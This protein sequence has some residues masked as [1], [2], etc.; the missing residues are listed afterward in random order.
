[1]K[2]ITCFLFVV[3]TMVPAYSLEPPKGWTEH[4]APYS[5]P[6]AAYQWLNVLLEASGRSVDRFGARPTIVSREMAIVVTAM[7]DAWAAYDD[8]AVGTRLR[9]TLRRPVEERTLQN[10]EIAIAYAAYRALKYV[11]PEDASWIEERMRGLGYDPHEGTT[12]PSK[13]QGVGNAAAA[14]VIEFRRHDGANQHG[15]EPGADGNPYSDYTF[16]EPRN[17]VDKIIEPDRWQQIPFS[18]GKGGIYYPG[19]LTPYWYRVKPFLLGRSDMFRPGP[20]PKVGSSQLK[21]EIDECIAFNSGLTLEQKAIVEFMR[22]GPRSTGQSGH[23]LQF[24]QDVSRRERYNLDQDVK[25]FFTI[26]NTAFDSF[27]ACWEAKRF[28]DSS[29]PW[30]LI[31]HCYQGRQIPGYKG[32]C[33]G[34]GEISAEQWFPYSPPTFVTPPFPGYPS[35]HSTLSGAC[36]KILEQFTRSDRFEAFERHRA[37]KYTEQDCDTRRMQAR[38]GKPS[39]DSPDSAEVILL[40]PTFTATAEMA[41]ISRVMGGYHIQADNVEGLKLGRAIADYS[42]PKY[43]SYFDGSAAIAKD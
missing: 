31:R 5:N 13:P 34:V 35:G 24:A 38:D 9:S 19:F 4:R 29:R 1:M 40:L 8:K 43:R 23:W 15:D 6:S 14:A 10:K 11:Y 17:P 16:Y 28:Y 30:T 33:Q 39:D 7:Y 27:I 22:D 37:G 20:F 26:G 36:S 2:S 21:K 25:L 42:W 3:L 12:D 18:D 32:A 41:G